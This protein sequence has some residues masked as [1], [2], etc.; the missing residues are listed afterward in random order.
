MTTTIGPIQ[1]E[2]LKQ[3]VFDF[4]EEMEDSEA[5]EPTSPTLRVTVKKGTD[6][7]PQDVVVDDED[8]PFIIDGQKVI[9]RIQYRVPNVTYFLQC[10]IHGN[11]G[12]QHT[13]TAELAAKEYA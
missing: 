4:V 1:R 13:L 3:V 5:I 11:T 8:P 7:A 6:P 2:E 12:L 9:W 10:N